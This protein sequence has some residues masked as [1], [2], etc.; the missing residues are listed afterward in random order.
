MEVICAIENMNLTLQI[1]DA[2][3]AAE[4]ACAS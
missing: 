3:I 2:S 4:M 1:P